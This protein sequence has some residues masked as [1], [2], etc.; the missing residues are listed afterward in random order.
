M[1]KYCFGGH[2]LRYKK[3]LGR[4]GS[5]KGKKTEGKSFQRTHFR[6]SELLSNTNPRS[7]VERDIMPALRLPDFPALWAEDVVGRELLR[8]GRVEVWT[9]V[10]V[11]RR[12]ADRG[13]FQDAN[14]LVSVGAAAG[15]EGGVFEGEADLCWVLDVSVVFFGGGKGLG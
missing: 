4:G 14:G 10:H 9:A 11:Q 13:V 6:Q 5:E 7:A 3:K 12:V 2:C 8:G 1:G 15:G